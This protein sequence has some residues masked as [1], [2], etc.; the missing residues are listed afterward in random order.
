MFSFCFISVFCFC[1]DG[2]LV[3]VS[4][5]SLLLY[6]VGVWS[7]LLFVLLCSCS[8]WLLSG[9]SRSASYLFCVCMM[10]SGCCF[11]GCVCF[12]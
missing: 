8:F 2:L 5:F 10:N 4:V 9:S 3:V 7:F 1:V 6:L 12:R 11:S